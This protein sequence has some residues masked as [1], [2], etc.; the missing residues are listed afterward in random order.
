MVS[1]RCLEKYT[2]GKTYRFHGEQLLHC[3]ML[4]DA[5]DQGGGELPDDVKRRTGIL[6]QKQDLQPDVPRH[7]RVQ[8]YGDP[9]NEVSQA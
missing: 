9:G 5:E 6:L 8:D 2:A 4:E 3:E 7:A 1:Y